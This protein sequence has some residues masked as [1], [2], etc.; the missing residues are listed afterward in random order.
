MA[1]SILTKC[2]TSSFLKLSNYSVHDIRTDV[3]MPRIRINWGTIAG[4][5]PEGM[6][7]TEDD[8]D[9]YTIRITKDSFIYAYAEYDTTDF[10]W[11]KSKI[12]VSDTS[13]C[14]ETNPPEPDYSHIQ[15]YYKLIGC[16]YLKSGVI[17]KI[18]TDIGNVSFH[19]RPITSRNRNL[20]IIDSTEV[21]GSP[22]IRIR[23][24][25][26]ANLQPE[27]F[28]PGD[29]P[30]YTIPLSESVF[31]YAAAELDPLR[32]IWKRSWIQTSPHELR[33]T[34]NIVYRLIG[35]VGIFENRI[36]SITNVPYG[37]VV[38]GLQDLNLYD[39]RER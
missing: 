30:Y 27:G 20:E 6:K 33:S 9:P 21:E 39:G 36:V 3:I 1:I 23:W 12:I 25:T 19:M 24:G 37:D 10:K 2:V 31:V 5:V 16:V 29:F 32:M 14:W 4:M 13:T 35:S 22:V 8:Y 34:A 15:Y 26:I 28:E 11:L 7:E 18:Y 38:L 17:D